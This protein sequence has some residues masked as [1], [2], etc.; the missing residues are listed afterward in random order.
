M[1]EELAK[2]GGES[3]AL[4]DVAKEPKRVLLEAKKAAQALVV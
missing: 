2:Y 1:T 4:I 3:V